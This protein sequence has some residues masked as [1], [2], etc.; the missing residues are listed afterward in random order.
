MKDTF[1]FLTSCSMI[2]FFVAGKS[3]EVVSCRAQDPDAVVFLSS[4][5]E[6]KI[7]NSL[8]S[9]A[10][11][12]PF[13]CLFTHDS[14]HSK[15]NSAMSLWICHFYFFF[16]DVGQAKAFLLTVE[17]SYFI[18]LLYKPLCCTM[19]CCHVSTEANVTQYFWWFQFNLPCPHMT[20]SFC[21]H[22]EI[23]LLSLSCVELVHN[24]TTNALLF[25]FLVE[26]IVIPYSLM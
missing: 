4:D 15:R 7:G 8:S 25:I 3:Y 23:L 26:L 1:N 2:F 24:P 12:C 6:P 20:C 14:Q 18:I 11:C 17:A 19:H 10:F 5:S 13:V 9:F 21:L 22:V 16:C